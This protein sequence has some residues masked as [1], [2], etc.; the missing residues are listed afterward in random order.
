MRSFTVAHML[1]H[2][3]RDADAV[4]RTLS[5]ES[6]GNVPDV[7]VDVSALQNHISYLDTCA[8]ADHPIGGW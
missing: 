8:E 5:L 7:T 3:A 2:G 6:G 1:T 4:R